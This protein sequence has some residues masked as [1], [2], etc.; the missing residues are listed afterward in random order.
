MVVENESCPCPMYKVIKRQRTVG[1]T[2]VYLKLYVDP[3]RPKKQCIVLEDLNIFIVML[4]I[5]VPMYKG[6]FYIER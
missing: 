2:H 3:E 4:H 5:L 1:F 6:T